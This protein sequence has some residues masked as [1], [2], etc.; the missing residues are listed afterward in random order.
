[1]GHRL[2]PITGEGGLAPSYIIP[3]SQEGDGLRSKARHPAD[4]F[5]P[6]WD[7]GGS[8][9]LDF[10]VTSGLRT[11]QLEQ[12]VADGL[13]SLTSYESIKDEY[14]GTAVHCAR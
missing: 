9:A 7:L 12:T 1:M 13:S 5:L 10:A 14:K 4:I 8:S 2:A 6:Q 3:A 11:L